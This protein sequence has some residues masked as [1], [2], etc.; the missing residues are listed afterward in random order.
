MAE[1]NSWPYIIKIFKNSN[2]DQ[3]TVVRII[4]LFRITGHVHKKPYPRK[5]AYRELT[6]PAELFVLN[7]VTEKPGIY[8]EEVKRE[9]KDFMM[10]DVSVSAICKLLHKNGFTRQKLHV[11]ALQRDTFLR[12]K[13]ILDVSV[14]SFEMLVFVNWC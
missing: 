14:Y 7:L 10:I 4:K 1:G 3:S 13:Y 2:V 9:L 12:E 5:R 11:V 6:E 8:L